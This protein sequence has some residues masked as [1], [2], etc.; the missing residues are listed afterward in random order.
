VFPIVPARASWG[1]AVVSR[2]YHSQESN[3][4]GF[5]STVGGASELDASSGVR[6][7]KAMILAGSRTAIAS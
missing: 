3:R 4:A 7:K 2:Q 6:I 1:H 5:E